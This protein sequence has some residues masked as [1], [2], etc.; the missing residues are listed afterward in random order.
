ME[1]EI[2]EVQFKGERK[3]F[4]LNSNSLALKI[5]DSVIVEVERG[6]DLGRVVQKGSLSARKR[7]DKD[8][9]LGA[10]RRPASREEL[11]KAAGRDQKDDEALKICHSKVLEHSLSMKL[12]DAEW[13]FDGNK[14]SFYFTAEK[15]VDFRQLVKDLAAIFKTRIELKQIGVRDEARRIGG[16]GR[17]GCKLCC[18]TFLQEFEP[19]TLRAAKDQRLSLNPSQISGICGR[20][21]CCLMYE[22]DFYKAQLKKFPKEGKEF[23]TGPGK[24]ERVTGLDIFNETVELCNSEGFRRKIPL[25]E[26]TEVAVEANPRRNRQVKQSQSSRNRKNNGEKRPLNGNGTA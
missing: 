3:E 1:A 18:T 9:R 24:P 12:V 20:L 5:G 11:E 23:S 19:V 17:C 21:M 10:I 8:G 22:R 2:V 4:Y 13:Q 25:E 14:I 16:C 15:R 6:E 7:S 26:F